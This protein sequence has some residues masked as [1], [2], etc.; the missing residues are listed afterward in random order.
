MFVQSREA[1]DTWMVVLIVEIVHT[2]LS[3]NLLVFNLSL[4]EFVL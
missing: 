1:L 4:F 2:Y 3:F